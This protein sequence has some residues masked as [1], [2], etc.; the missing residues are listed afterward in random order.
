MSCNVG[1][2]CY[3]PHM[4][5]VESH[6]AKSCGDYLQLYYDTY[7]ATDEPTP[8]IS[9]PEGFVAVDLWAV[10]ASGFQSAIAVLSHVADLDATQ[11]IDNWSREQVLEFLE[12]KG[13]V[14][15]K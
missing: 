5:T 7:F 1:K 14:T 13:K 9:Y 6:W 11:A 3:G 2:V 12:F 15:I 10:H 4:I 8:H